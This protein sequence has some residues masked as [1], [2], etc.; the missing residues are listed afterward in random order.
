MANNTDYHNIQF[1]SMM[2]L[3]FLF[4]YAPILHVAQELVRLSIFPNS[5]MRLAETECAIKLM[6]AMLLGCTSAA[7]KE[8][9]VPPILYAIMDVLVDEKGD[10]GAD[11]SPGP[12][13]CWWLPN[14]QRDSGGF[15]G[16]PM[17]VRD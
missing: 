14:M 12:Q 6:A 16:L 8:V 17:N 13:P 3:L 9:E 1:S 10:L 5:L 7:E 15:R 2:Q 11:D 4:S